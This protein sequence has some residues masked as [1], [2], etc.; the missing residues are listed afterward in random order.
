MRFLRLRRWQ[1]SVRVRRRSWMHANSEFASAEFDTIRELMMPSEITS[2]SACRSRHWT[3]IGRTSVNNA[4]LSRTSVR[5]V[6]T[7][8]CSAVACAGVMRST[9]VAQRSIVRSSCDAVICAC[10]M[11][12]DF[13]LSYTI[14]SYQDGKAIGRAPTYFEGPVQGLCHRTRSAFLDEISFGGD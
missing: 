7:A 6:S 13:P 3:T 8:S 4:V 1:G 12:R 2:A 11:V 9:S 5:S 10:A 14:K